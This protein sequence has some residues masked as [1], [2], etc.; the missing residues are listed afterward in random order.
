[1][2]VAD[3]VAD[4]VT[5]GRFWVFPHPEFVELAAQRWNSIAEGRNPELGVETPGMPSSEQLAS[6]IAALLAPPPS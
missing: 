3:L 6:E 5:E 1:M 4:A 2:V